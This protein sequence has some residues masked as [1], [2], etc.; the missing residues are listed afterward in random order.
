MWSRVRARCRASR[1]PAK[2]ASRSGTCR[3]RMGVVNGDR[4]WPTDKL[5]ALRLGRRLVAEV[6]TSAVGRRGFIRILPEKEAD[7]AT[8]D[9]DRWTRASTSPSFLVDHWEY[10]EQWL[11]TWDYD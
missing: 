5:N 7:D 10:D 1:R 3:R 8:A 11:G 9:A 2:T 6:P 4:G